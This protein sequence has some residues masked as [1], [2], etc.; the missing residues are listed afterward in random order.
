[1]HIGKVRQRVEPVATSATAQVWSAGGFPLPGTLWVR[2]VAGNTFTVDYSTDGGT[3][4]QSLASLTG[5]A[6][7]T[8]TQVTSGFTHMKITP[9]GVQGGQWGVC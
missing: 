7:Y 9:S 8:E 3:T 1:M 4:Y 2:P 5:A 6:A